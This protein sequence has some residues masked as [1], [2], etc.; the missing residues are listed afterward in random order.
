MIHHC[1]ILLTALMLA[2][3]INWLVNKLPKDLGTAAYPIK[4]RLP[5]I[6][7]C[8]ISLASL[9]TLYFPAFAQAW[10]AL[11]F[12][13]TLVTLT[14]IDLESQLLPDTLT[15]SLLWLG[16]LLSPWRFDP[17]LA[18]WGAALG[19]LSLLIVAKTYCWA[20]GQEGLGM[21]DCKL[22]AAFGAW[23]GPHP[24][25]LLI[26]IAAIS[27]L[28]V[29]I[30]RGCRDTASF[31]KPLAFGPYL[32]LSGLML[33]FVGPHTTMDWIYSLGVL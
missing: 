18:I 4:H 17:T 9:T 31:K 10:S 32:G 16:L 30:A 15:L 24:L 1:L 6:Y 21:G 3:P 7:L 11:V 13:L 33:Y 25:P 12:S 19:Y 27:G 29:G 20:R 5:L 23:F 8:N 14:L 22:L 28:I 26:L 2:Q